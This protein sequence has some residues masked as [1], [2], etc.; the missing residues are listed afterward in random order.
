M[1]KFIAGTVA[2]I[3]FIC[4]AGGCLFLATGCSNAERAHFWSAG[5]AHHIIHYSGSEKIGEWDSTGK[6]Q[7]EGKSCGYYFE[8][9]ATHRPVH[10]SGHVTITIK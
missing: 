7:N 3:F 2:T 4:I 9:A 1:S 8:D 5:Q 6:V 10:I